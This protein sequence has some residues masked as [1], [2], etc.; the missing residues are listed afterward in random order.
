MRGI[1]HQGGQ[2]S[3]GLGKGVVSP[4]VYEV[5]EKTVPVK[6]RPEAT[7]GQQHGAHGE[8]TALLIDPFE[9]AFGDVGHANSPGRAVE[10]LIAIPRENTG[11]LYLWPGQGILLL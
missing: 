8:A 7:G 3:L 2:S 9:V 5:Q 10:E 11:S 4:G 1:V 6:G